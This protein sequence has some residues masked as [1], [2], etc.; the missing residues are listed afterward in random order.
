[1]PASAPTMPAPTP[2]AV[3]PPS[4]SPAAVPAPSGTPQTV[5][6]VAPGQSQPQG[7]RTPLGDSEHGA[8]ILLLD[9]VQ[10]LLDKAADEQTEKVSMDR[11]LID[12]MRAEITQV[13]M[14][15][16]RQNR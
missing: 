16:Q 3:M 4:G 5:P 14:T 15:L 9:R 12:E 1:M 10:K 8:A 7:S 6:T 11:G 13:K 2:G